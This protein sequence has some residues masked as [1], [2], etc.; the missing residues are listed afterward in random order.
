VSRCL[1]DLALTEAA[2]G[3]IV[4]ICS[5]AATSLR[6]LTGQLIAASGK[7]VVVREQ[8]GRGSA[9]RDIKTSAGSTAR[10]LALG[11]TPPR[12]AAGDTV[13]TMLDTV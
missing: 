13:R 9:T 2:C 12:P 8:G 5:G 4:N 3:R 1:A 6:H 10:L 11:I 7:S